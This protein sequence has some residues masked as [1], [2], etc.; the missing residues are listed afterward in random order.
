MQP[1]KRT[2]ENR[3]KHANVAGLVVTFAVHALALLLCLTLGLRYLDPPPPERTTLLIEFDEQVPEEE[4]VETRIGREP[5]AE[6]NDPER[7]VELVR[8]AQSP[9]VNDRPNTTPASTPDSHGD[10]D[11]PV[12]QEPQINPNALFPGMS[13]NSESNATTPHSATEAS[14]NFSAGQPDG[15]TREGRIDGNANARLQ[16]RNVVGSLPKPAYNAQLEGTVVVQ[17]KVDQYGNVTEA[18]AGV[19]GTTVHDATLWNAARNAAM[20]AHFNMKADAP[21][22][23]T[24]TITYIFKLQ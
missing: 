6:V 16:G 12:P 14:T 4:P 17:I 23:Q 2:Q 1:Y 19:E 20:R 13:S 15:N 7:E 18:V 10:V 24:G 22:L 5:Q 9:F 8:E 21:V 11:I 3:E